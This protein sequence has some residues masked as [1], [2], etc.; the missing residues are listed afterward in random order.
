MTFVNHLVFWLTKIYYFSVFIAFPIFKLGFSSW[1]VGYILMNAMMGL[2]LSV[3]F[4]LAHVV[5]N[6]EFEHVALDENK[7]IE[8][9]WAEHQVKT[10]SNFAMD[11]KIVSWFVG[12]LNF[13]IE[14]HLF[15][16]ISHVHYPA[17]SKI[18][19][20]SCK[21][22]GLPYNH[23]DTTRAAILSHLRTM[24]QLGKKPMLITQAA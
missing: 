19:Q 6:T 2:A 22:F 24:K 12:G 17:I 7:H 8:S 13:Q 15:P 9:A 18:V 11:N 10:T 3:V 14:H 23:F 21:E 5:E 16:K 4:Q 20:Q 1:L